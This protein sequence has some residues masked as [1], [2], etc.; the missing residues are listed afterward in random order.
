[1][2]WTFRWTNKF[3]RRKQWVC[4]HKFTD[5]ESALVKVIGRDGWPSVRECLLCSERTI[6]E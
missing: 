6:I 5:G 2:D 4:Q 1:M 3:T